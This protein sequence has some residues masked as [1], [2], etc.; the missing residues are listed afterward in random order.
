MQPNIQKINTNVQN[1]TAHHPPKSAHQPRSEGKNVNRTNL[2]K[3]VNK[4]SNKE[5][6]QKM[7]DE[8]K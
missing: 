3:K 5:I 4:L 1:K 6:L 2:E 7:L 8:N